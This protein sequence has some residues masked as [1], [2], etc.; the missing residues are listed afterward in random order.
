M[1]FWREDLGLLPPDDGDRLLMDGNGDGWDAARAFSLT[2]MAALAYE[3]EDAVRDFL[4]QRNWQLEEYR[5]VAHRPLLK[6]WS[7]TGWFAARRER[8]LILAFRGTEP[9]NLLNWAT[10]LA[11]ATVSADRYIPGGSG[12]IH[13]GFAEAFAVVWPTVEAR[14]RDFAANGGSSIWITGH[15]LGGALALLVAAAIGSNHSGDG[16]S[17]LAGLYTCGQPR[18]G[19]KAFVDAAAARVGGRYFRIVHGND[20]VPHLPPEFLAPRWLKRAADGDQPDYAHGGTL[21]Y[22]PADTGEPTNSLPACFP[23]SMK[24]VAVRLAPAVPLL[25]RLALGGRD[26]LP[27]LP[28]DLSHHFPRGTAPEQSAYISRLRS[29]LRP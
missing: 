28:T 3:P 13:A 12:R 11:F 14:V 6:I 2:N 22:L 9:P 18:V 10:N 17:R 16:A 23:V 29:L 7:H 24:E 26:I 20:I 5:S 15:S 21:Y 1:S 19:D 25:P 27:K 8:D 4:A